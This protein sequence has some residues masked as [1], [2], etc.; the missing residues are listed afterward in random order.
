[1]QYPDTDATIGV[2]H[3]AAQGT[4]RLAA[5]GASLWLLFGAVTRAAA[6]HLH[7]HRR[8][9]AVARGA[10]AAG[11]R[12]A[13]VAGRARDG[14]R[15]ADAHRDAVLSLGRRRHRPAESRRRRRRRFAP[16]PRSCRASTRSR[17]TARILAYTLVSTWCVALLCGVLPAIR[18]PRGLDRRASR[19]CG[20]TQV[21]VRHGAAVDAGW[22]AGR[23]LGHAARRRR[24]ARRAASTSCRASMPGFDAS[25][26]LTLPHQRQLRRDGR[27]TTACSRASIAA[28]RALRA[29]A[30]R[31]GGRDRRCACR[32]CR[33]STSRHST[34]S[35]RDGDAGRRHG[36]R[37]AHRVA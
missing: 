23:A 24:A 20:R 4:R 12:R 13:L 35:K 25:R 29:I 5:C 3:R 28:S 2:E 18:A 15:G 19:E 14:D 27:T 21:S 33:S 34:W 30:G 1:M 16:P 37:A 8:A 36:R 22:R 10:A 7:E 26:V 31:R 11:N 17:S 9:A 32:A 6:D